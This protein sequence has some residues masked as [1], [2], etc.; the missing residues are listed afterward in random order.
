MVKR[1]DKMKKPLLILLGLFFIFPCLSMADDFLGAPLIP[2]G[3]VVK[4]TAKRLEMTVNL[5]HDEVLAFY[6]EK[7]SRNPDTKYRDWKD[8]TYI[9]DDGKQAWH[10]IT[11]SKG[12]SPETTIIIIKDNWTWII[13]TL[14]IRFV[15]VF[16][17]LIVLLIVLSVS[18]RII[19]RFFKETKAGAPPAATKPS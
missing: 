18:G 7:L 10:S 15:G 3:K 14:I 13:G 19:S 17:V 4:K 6:K 12:S 1:I 16:I 8:V 2:S 5:S 11:I 9:E